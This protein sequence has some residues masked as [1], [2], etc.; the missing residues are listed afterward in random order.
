MHFVA[1]VVP[2]LNLDVPIAIFGYCD[3]RNTLYQIHHEVAPSLQVTAS[4]GLRV[5]SSIGLSQDEFFLFKA[6]SD[7]LSSAAN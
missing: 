1:V 6:L 4:W 5:D 2:A 7:L 3:Q